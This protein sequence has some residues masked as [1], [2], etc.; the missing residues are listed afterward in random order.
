MLPWGPLSTFDILPPEDK[1][2][3]LG[4]VVALVLAA[5]DDAGSMPSGD[6][7]AAATL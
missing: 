4:V 6:R 2:E 1:D 7:A 3:V 5:F